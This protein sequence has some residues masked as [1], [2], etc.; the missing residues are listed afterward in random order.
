MGYNSSQENARDDVLIDEAEIENISQLGIGCIWSENKAGAPLD[1]ISI[2]IRS[3]DALGVIMRMPKMS[4][5]L[6][7]LIFRRETKQQ[8][9][10]AMS[11]KFYT[12]QSE[13]TI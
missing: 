11:G 5:I 6:G 3:Q 10:G 7:E 13:Y 4:R 2:R 1:P 12:R 8:G 9:K